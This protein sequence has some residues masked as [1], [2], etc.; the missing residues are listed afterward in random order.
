MPL[1][2]PP[3]VQNFKQFFSSLRHE[4]GQFVVKRIEQQLE[5]EASAWLQRG[6]HERR[7]GSRRQT[8]ACC[9]RCG[10]RTAARFSRNGH[11]PRQMVTSFGV[12]S[13]WLPRAVCECG[14]SVRLPFSI[15]Q[16]HQRLWDDVVTQIGRWADLGLSLRQMQTEIGDQLGAQVG[17]RKLNEVVQSVPQPTALTLTSVPPV[18]LLDAIWVDLLTPTAI[19]ETDAVGRQRPL[20][21]EG[22]VCILVALGIYPQSGRW[23]VL[24]WHL[25]ESESQTAW[26][27]LLLPLE[28]RGLYRQRG[29]ELFIHDGSQ[30][31]IA[32][33]NFIH[34]HVPHQRC[35]FHKLRNLWHDIQ[36]DA[37]C[38]SGERQAF[39]QTLIQQVTP[40][41]HADDAAHAQTIRDALTC[42]WHVDQPRFVATLR[43]DWEQTVAFFRV[44]ERFPTWPRRFLRTTSLLERVNQML[45]RLF[46]SAGAFHSSS[47][48]LAAVRR[49]LL[50]LRLI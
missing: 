1:K 46:R 37:D 44:L 8:Q 34:P 30:G 21:A 43:R 10:S 15:V 36:P 33:L 12:L 7:T 19:L 25:A 45:R 18:I 42:Q 29:V 22:D 48:L 35:W 14:G 40:L 24:A 47:G 28:Q 27:A 32:A 3:T 2:I 31:L 39:K 5:V 38:S 20:K 50:P 26:E 6:Y 9:Q 4:M 11:R 49:V 13:Y 16:P 23:G 17:L 41:L